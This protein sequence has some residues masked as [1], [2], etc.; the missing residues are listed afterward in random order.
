M[1]DPEVLASSSTEFDYRASMRLIDGVPWMKAADA[2][3]L[4]GLALHEAS[5]RATRWLI[6]GMVLFFWLGV[7][8][9]WR[10]GGLWR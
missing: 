8:A 7:V 1:S 2:H 6:G 3:V 4:M 9:G 10:W 5:R